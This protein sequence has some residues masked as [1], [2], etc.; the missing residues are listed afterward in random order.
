VSEPFYRA[1]ARHWTAMGD[2]HWRGRWRPDR[3]R[4]EAQMRRWREV[5]YIEEVW[6]ERLTEAGPVRHDPEEATP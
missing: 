2:E 4:A 3:S 1:V 5:D 6:V